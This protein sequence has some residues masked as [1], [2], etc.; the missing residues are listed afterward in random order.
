VVARRGLGPAF[1]NLFTAN[2]ASSLGDGIARVAAPLLAARLTDDPLLISGIAALALL[3]WLFFAIPAGILVDRIDRRHALALANGVR[4]ALA[5]A[6]FVLVATDGL[7]IWWLYLVTFVYGAFETVYD[8]AIRAIVPSIVER[9]NLSRANARIEGGELVVQNFLSGPFTSVLFAVSALIPLGVNAAVFGGA[10]ALAF[11]LPKAAS[12]GQFARP[13]AEEGAPWHRQ[14]TDGYHFIIRNRML[15][16]LWFFS[17]FTGIAFTAATASFVLFV[18][19]TLRVPE[20]WFGFFMLSGAV[21]GIVGSVV[22]GPLKDRWGTGLTVAIMT[23][24]TGAAT[25]AIGAVPTIA[26]AAV[27][28]ALTSGAITVWNIH[29]MSLRQSVIPGRLLGRVHGTWRTLLWGAMP[30]G[31]ILGG[32]LGRIDLTVPFL[33]GGGVSLAA[34]VVFFRFLMTLPNAEDVDNG[35]LP[36]GPIQPPGITPLT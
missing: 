3:P 25:V 10:L 33:V 21:G 31:A 6:L 29:I 16:T 23:T 11:F 30:V 22:A 14:F 27:G 20:V 35:D 15:R 7:T 18:L 24:V 32:L 13:V 19:D 4:V 1:A 26:V 5:I 12:G 36:V 2:L 28:T 17:T 9:S 34:S 8:G